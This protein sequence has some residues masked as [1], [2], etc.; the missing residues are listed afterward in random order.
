MP[1]KSTTATPPAQPVMD[2]DTFLE[3]AGTKERAKIEKYLATCEASPEPGRAKLWRTLATTLASH[4]PLAIQSSGKDAWQFFVPDGKYRKQVFALEDLGDGTVQ[5]YLP[6][7]LQQATKEKIL[8]K[9]DVPNEFTLPK[10]RVTL[11]VDA[12]DAAN[13]PAPPPHYKH[14][15]GW[16]RKALRITLS[17]RDEGPQT[18]AAA[19]LLE[20]A[21]REW[22]AATPAE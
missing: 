16:N 17:A 1:R 14:M 10:S 9:T 13:T 19:A 6:D 3:K 5:I 11:K 7:I 12:L 15:L 21:A 4:T 22:A 18:A 8:A 20:I 2:F